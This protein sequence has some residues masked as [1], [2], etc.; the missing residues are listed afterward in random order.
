M[1]VS[2]VQLSLLVGG[3]VPTPAPP[4]LMTALQ[5]LEVNQAGETSG[6]QMTFRAERRPGFSLDYGLL[7]GLLL[8][9]GNRVVIVVTVSATPSVLMDGII[10]NHQLAPDSAGATQLTVTG[11]DISVMMSMAEVTMEYP[12]LGDT[13][14]ALLVL[15]KYALYGV[16]PEVVPA[17]T[18]LVSLPIEEIPQQSGNDR[19]YLRT[20]AARNG[21]VFYVQPG[22]LPLMSRGY[23]GPVF[24][25]GVPQKALTVNM[26]A[27]TNVES[28]NFSYNALAPEQ[29]Y[30]AVSDE[31]GEIILPVLTVDSIQLQ[32]LASR[33]PLI[34]NQPFVRRSM[35]DYQGSSWI[36]AEAYAQSLTN[37]STEEVVTAQGTLD[38]LRY[39]AILTA[40]GFVGVRGVGMT[41]DGNYYVKSVSHQISL[42]QYKQSFTL[43][44]EGTGSLTMGVQP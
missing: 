41:Y 5:S 11:E 7:D 28:I 39:G 42:G 40:P 4:Q 13:E 38:V 2:S 18:S 15:A 35:L 43:A 10:T 44:R 33:P 31:E 19:D 27:A 22:P 20:L 1:N 24:R 30:G 32:P 16:V 37:R 6:F 36:E 25:I 23:W 29:I 3:T 17:L 34:F 14:I 9:P 8:Q 12:G 21:Y 26:G